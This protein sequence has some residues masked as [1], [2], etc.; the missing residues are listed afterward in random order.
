MSVKIIHIMWN[1]NIGGAERAVYQLIR[2]QRRLGINSNLMILNKMGYYGEMCKESGAEVHT[3]DMKS[4]YD[5]SIKNKFLETAGKYDI[6]NIHVPEPYPIYILSKLE[7]TRLYYTHRGGLL[8]YGLKKNVKHKI[9]GYYFR[10]FYTGFSANT[11]NASYAANKFFGIPRDRIHITYNGIDFDLFQSGKS[12]NDIFRELCIKGEKIIIGTVANFRKLKRIDILIK[13]LKE[14]R[15]KDYMCIIIGDGPEK[16]N[17]VRLTKELGLSEKIMFIG[18]RENIFDYLQIFDIF[19]LP[20]DISESFGNSAVEAMGFG[21]PSIVMRDGGGLLEHI[22][23]GK[24]GLI[25]NDT[26]HLSGLLRELIGNRQLRTEI[27]ENG[28]RYIKGKYS[29]KKMID[30]YNT[31][32]NLKPDEAIPD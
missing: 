5:I 7:N 16:K 23:P 2:E 27:G 10:R 19:V 15:N 18:S 4:A 17:L 25:A 30:S 11:V 22:I 21:V 20:S 31:L 26:E 32:Y 28:K 1:M 24:T 6:I 9:C 14:I 8:N 13:S 12:K 3:L 29:L